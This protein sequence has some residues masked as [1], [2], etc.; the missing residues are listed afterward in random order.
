MQP[1][2][3]GNARVPRSDRCRNYPLPYRVR[4][5][6]RLIV[7]P[8]RPL[9]S[10]ILTRFPSALPG[11]FS[12]PTIP[13]GPE[14][15]GRGHDRE[16]GSC[17]APNGDCTALLVPTVAKPHESASRG[18]S[19]GLAQGRLQRSVGLSPLGAQERVPGPEPAFATKTPSHKEDRPEPGD[20]RPL[21]SSTPGILSVESST[22]G[23]LPEHSA[24]SSPA[25]GPGSY[26]DN[27]LDELYNKPWTSLPMPARFSPWS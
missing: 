17:P 2:D 10:D 14:R 9:S 13:A 4:P 3:S 6:A 1:K 21:E 22:P 11:H 26:V 18:I 15:Q 16:D 7:T 20:T 25:A 24:A 8:A 12:H 27:S 23:S 19:Q 5:A